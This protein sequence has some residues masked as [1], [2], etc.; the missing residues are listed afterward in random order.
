MYSV[1]STAFIC[2]YDTVQMLEFLL[3]LSILNYVLLFIQ[4]VDTFIIIPKYTHGII[5]RVTHIK[6]IHHYSYVL[7]IFVTQRPTRIIKCK[8]IYDSTSASNIQQSAHRMEFIVI[9][10]WKC[11]E[12]IY[13]FHVF[14]FYFIIDF[15]FAYMLQRMLSFE[16]RA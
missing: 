3:A 10:Y 14:N 11:S 7:H 4:T 5:F 6:I 8:F 16:E 2:Q 12:Y 15:R 9:L 13:T 1:H